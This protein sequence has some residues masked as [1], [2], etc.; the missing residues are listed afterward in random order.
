MSIN[1]PLI[2]TL[3]VLITGLIWLYDALV[4]A[5]PRRAAMEAVDQ[6]FS[7]L[8]IAEEQKQAAYADA[9]QTA[10]REPVLVEYAKSFFPV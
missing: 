8:N 1:L 9:Q 6:Q 5:R 7:K 3:A 10:G 2:L 4:L